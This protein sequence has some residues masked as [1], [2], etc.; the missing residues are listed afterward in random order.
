MGYISNSEKVVRATSKYFIYDFATE[1]G[2]VDVSSWSLYFSL[3]ATQEGDNPI[4]TK[5]ESD[6]EYIIKESGTKTG[7]IFNF[8]TDDT[9]I[10]P[11]IY[12]FIL[13]FQNDEGL[14]CLH[15][16]T[17]LVEDNPDII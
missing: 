9:D 7:F 13:Q 16:S 2:E 6:A 12:Y 8:N 15:K 11:G 4:F 5:R 14:F 10:E 1:T 17:L 3:S